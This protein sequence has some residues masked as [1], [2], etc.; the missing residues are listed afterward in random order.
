MNSTALNSIY[1]HDIIPAKA[2]GFWPPAPGW[3]ILSIVLLLLA[4][5]TSK[6][7]KQYLYQR[8]FEKRI[9][10]ELDTLSKNY[11]EQLAINISKLLRR[12]ALMRYA[13]EEVASLNGDAWLRFLDKTGG[14]GG[15]QMG[16]GQILTTLPYSTNQY[17]NLHDNLALLKLAR[18]WI[19]QNSRHVN[20][21]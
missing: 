2:A 10:H 4:Y 11:P 6:R 20:E 8:R 7:L 13:R 3:W 5:F 14:N 17:T 1:L 19:Q 9:L 21:Y 15:F 12:V 16:V 18:N